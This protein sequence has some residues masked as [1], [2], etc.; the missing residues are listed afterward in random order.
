MDISKES[1]YLF[2]FAVGLPTTQVLVKSE[3]YPLYTP[4]I[5]IVTRSFLSTFFQFDAKAR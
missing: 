4:P 5:S 2:C 3:P 1:R